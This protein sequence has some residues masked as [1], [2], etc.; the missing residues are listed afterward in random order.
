MKGIR[1]GMVLVALLVMGVVCGCE[2]TEGNGC[3]KTDTDYQQMMALKG[4]WKFESG[5][6]TKTYHLTQLWSFNDSCSLQ[7]D[8]VA[9]L[10][11]KNRYFMTDNMETKDGAKDDVSFEFLLD[12]TGDKIQGTAFKIGQKK[13]RLVGYRQ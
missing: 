6:I 8:G 5:L 1:A 11:V 13:Y 9:V 12:A 2:R 7:D 10:W 4:V 3:K